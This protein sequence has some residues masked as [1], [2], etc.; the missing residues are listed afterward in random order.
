MPK[1]FNPNQPCIDLD[2]IES[3]HIADDTTVAPPV[4]NI[5]FSAKSGK[6]YTWS[7]PDPVIRDNIYRRVR[8]LYGCVE[9]I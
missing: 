3:I 8:D 2:A 6:V 1:I 9:V 7:F 5:V 4:Y